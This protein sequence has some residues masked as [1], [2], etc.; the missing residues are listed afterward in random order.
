VWRVRPAAHR[1]F[2]PM[3][4]KSPTAMAG[5]TEEARKYSTPRSGFKLLTEVS[6]SQTATFSK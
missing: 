2:D 1:D 4:A 5:L 3:N 6:I